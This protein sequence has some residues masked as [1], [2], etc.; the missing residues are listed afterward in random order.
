[1]ITSTDTL[2]IPDFVSRDSLEAYQ[3][4]TIACT[5]DYD[6]AFRGNDGPIDWAAGSVATMTVSKPR[7]FTSLDEVPDDFDMQAAR[8]YCDDPAAAFC[9]HYVRKGWDCSVFTL[10]GDVQADWYDVAIATN[11]DFSDAASFARDLEDWL[12]GRVYVVDFYAPFK[13]GDGSIHWEHVDSLGSV[14]FT[15]MGDEDKENYLRELCN[16]A[17]VPDSVSAYV[18]RWERGEVIA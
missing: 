16:E 3:F 10:R 5:V 1:M 15:D 8:D 6:D 14:Y 4:G 13:F 9:R 2:Q 11:P 18:P 7:G 17:D 12:F